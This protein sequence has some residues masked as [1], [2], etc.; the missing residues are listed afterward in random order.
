MFEDCSCMILRPVPVEGLAHAAVQSVT[1]RSMSLVEAWCR[2]EFRNH[3]SLTEL[4]IS[5]FR[6][7][8]S[9]ETLMTNF[10]PALHEG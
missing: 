7:I 4:A 5:R 1:A 3:I 6:P 10:L 8:Q 9:E 2:G